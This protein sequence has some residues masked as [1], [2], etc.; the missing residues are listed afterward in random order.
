MTT[1]ASPNRT[2]KLRLFEDIYKYPLDWL[3][4]LRPKGEALKVWLHV[5][6]PLEQVV[7]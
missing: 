5:D 4:E 7:V 1:L 6:A 3:S 2:I